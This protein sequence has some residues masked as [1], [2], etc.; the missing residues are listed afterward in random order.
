MG[1]I[2]PEI[3]ET[4]ASVH[5]AVPSGTT[6]CSDLDSVGNDGDQYVADLDYVQFQVPATGDWDL[7]LRWD[8]VGDYDLYV[9]EVDHGDWTKIDSS[10]APDV[11]SPEGTTTRLVKGVTYGFEVAGWSGSPGDWTVELTQ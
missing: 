5:G 8:V 9:F 7:D 11:H 3:G 1:S 2:V 10:H 6:F 4:L